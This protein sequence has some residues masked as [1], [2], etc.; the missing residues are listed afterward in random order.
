M[1]SSGVHRS[2]CRYGEIDR[3]HGGREATA[4]P[5][6]GREVQ[7]ASDGGIPGPGHGLPASLARMACKTQGWRMEMRESKKL[8]IS[9]SKLIERDVCD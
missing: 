4:G 6:D 7:R 9:P 3:L 8:A 5:K 1:A 2:R